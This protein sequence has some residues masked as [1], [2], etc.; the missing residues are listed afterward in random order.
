MPPSR[1]RARG[2]SHHETSR[3]LSRRELEEKLE[4]D[5]HDR[6]ESYLR[7][8]RD[9]AIA[10]AS[11]SSIA[12]TSC[13]LDELIG[14]LRGREARLLTESGAA[15]V[16]GMYDARRLDLLS[17]FQDDLLKLAPTLRSEGR[18]DEERYL[19]FYEAYFS[20]VLDGAAFGSTRPRRS[21]PGRVP[22]GRLAEARVLPWR[23]AS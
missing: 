9:E 15:R 13:W 14:A 18:G 8:L 10:L 23:S 19:P 7:A 4:G 20:S 2:R 1:A 21:R 11:R 5:L 22:R 6:G 3:R 16:A 17:V 12:R